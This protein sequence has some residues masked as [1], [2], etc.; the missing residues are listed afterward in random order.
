VRSLVQEIVKKKPMQR[1]CILLRKNPP[2]QA[3][4]AGGDV[5]SLVVEILKKKKRIL[6]KSAVVCLRNAMFVAHVRR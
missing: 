4:V 1:E 6:R 2:P 3:G 5:R